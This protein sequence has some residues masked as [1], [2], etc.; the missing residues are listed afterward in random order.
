MD[1][2]LRGH[3]VSFVGSGT[4][5]FI[6]LSAFIRDHPRSSAFKTNVR[7]GYAQDHS[8]DPEP[9][10]AGFSHAMNAECRG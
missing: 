3:D 7:I 4:L 6:A 8:G 9:G 1:A 2:R 10:D 5:F